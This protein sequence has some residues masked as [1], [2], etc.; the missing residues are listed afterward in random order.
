MGNTWGAPIEWGSRPFAE[1]D[2]LLQKFVEQRPAVNLDAVANIRWGK[3]STWGFLNSSGY[4][5]I[6]TTVIYPTD[7]G[8][9][10]EDPITWYDQVAVDTED[11]RIE[12]PDDSEQYVI[13]QRMTQGVWKS[14][15][16]GAMI[17]LTFDWDAPPTASLKTSSE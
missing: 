1:A 6:N 8:D 17:G 7:P 5:N 12:N 11:V 2:A 4:T 15:V 10:D 9:D 3:D 13:D 14:R 16:S